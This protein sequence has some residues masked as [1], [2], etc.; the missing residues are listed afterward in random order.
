[1]IEALSTARLDLEPLREAHAEL[2][3]DLFL[4]D[5]VWTY[6]PHLRPADRAAVHARLARWL[7]PPPPEMPE[8]L[9]FENWVGFQRATRAVVGTFQATIVRDGSA[10]VG[11]IVFPEHWRR[12]FA[13]EAMSAVCD[14]LRDAHAIRRIIADMD[15]RND[16]SAAVA[17]RLGMVEVAAANAKDR[18]FAWTAGKPG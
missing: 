6:L 11:Y 12:G 2:L 1:V 17:R 16:G 4:D 10:T 13:V 18:A 9:A 3:V 14:H 5:R 15:R 8:A 7:A